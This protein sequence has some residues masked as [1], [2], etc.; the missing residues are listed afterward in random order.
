M[1][2]CPRKLLPEESKSMKNIY[3]T[4]RRTVSADILRV[5]MAEELS[6]IELS[7]SGKE[8]EAGEDPNPKNFKTALSEIKGRNTSTK[9]KELE[10][11][12]LILSYQAKPVRA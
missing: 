6:I 7:K 10:M 1:M 11:L 12:K 8:K 5:F 4:Y 9:G 3:P 2:T